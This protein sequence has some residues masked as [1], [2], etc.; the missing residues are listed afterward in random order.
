MDRTARR[1]EI[2]LRIIADAAYCAQRTMRLSLELLL[3]RELELGTITRKDYDKLQSYIY[4]ATDALDGMKRYASVN[5]NKLELDAR[6]L[7]EAEEA[8]AFQAKD[9]NEFNSM[10]S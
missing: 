7:A 5:A 6:R 9:D 2:N 3:S 8:S 1:R 10:Q 4:T